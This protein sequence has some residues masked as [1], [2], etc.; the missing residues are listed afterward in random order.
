[1]TDGERPIIEAVGLVK[2][3][4]ERTAVD[5]LSLAV[6]TGEI[7]GF[8]GPNG[9]GKTTTILMLLGILEP[10]AGVAR[11]NGHEA[12]PGRLQARQFI[13]AVS[14]TQ[15]LYPDMTV[16][17]YLQFFA[18]LY[19]LDDSQR[20][21]DELLDEVRLLD[22]RRSPTVEL[23]R[24]MQQKLGMARALLHDPPALILDEPVSGLDPHGLR[25]V[26]D[27]IVEQRD[28]GRSVLL[29]SHVLAEVEKTA[30]RVGIISQG[31][32]IT[33]ASPQDIVG[34]LTVNGPL[35]VEVD[36]DASELVDVL[37]AVDGVVD[38]HASGS[39]LHLT[40]DGERQT[41]QRVSQAIT[42]TG[43]VIVRLNDPNVSLED[44]FIQLTS[45]E[46]DK[47]KASVRG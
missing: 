5:D 34:Q 44:A 3:Y 26:R 40:T 2:H 18:R 13:G 35:D 6:R 4:G 23:S 24:G 10:D 29:S 19:R 1:M 31:R 28:R 27:L 32:L 12:G 39:V 25:E 21:I 46:I 41:R 7:Y 42:A 47:L 30:D 14:E 20:R 36:T 33:E 15:F 9:A 17:E 8:L 22:R 11:I 38:V 16:G 37:A 45:H 43:A